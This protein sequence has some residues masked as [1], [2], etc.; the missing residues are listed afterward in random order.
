MKTSSLGI[1]LSVLLL[2]ACANNKY[3]AYVD[4]IDPSVP[5]PDVYLKTESDE[6]LYFVKDGHRTCGFA[7]VRAEVVPYATTIIAPRSS[8]VDCSTTTVIEDKEY[9]DGLF[10]LSIDEKDVIYVKIDGSKT[11]VLM[12]SKVTEAKVRLRDKTYSRN[13]NSVFEYTNIKSG[14]QAQIA[15]FTAAELGQ[16]FDIAVVS[17]FYCDSEEK[18]DSDDRKMSYKCQ[19]VKLFFAYPGNTD[20]LISITLTPSNNDMF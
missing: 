12:G 4:F 7:D 9:Q 13:D 14:D 15:M 11:S 6:K 17:T 16:D 18:R 2:S 20:P 5:H 19:R 10:S 8:R 3:R 1:L